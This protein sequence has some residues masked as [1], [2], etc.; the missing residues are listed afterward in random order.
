MQYQ[1]QVK[2]P[3]SAHAGIRHYE[4]A[5]DARPSRLAAGLVGGS[6]ASRDMRSPKC[7]LVHLG[8]HVSPVQIEPISQTSSFCSWAGPPRANS[9]T[10]TLSAREG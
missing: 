2:D 7:A 6:A 1:D 10:R 9:S 4:N 5:L 3:G 8:S